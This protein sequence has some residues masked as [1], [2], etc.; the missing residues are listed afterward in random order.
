MTTGLWNL[1]GW[2]FV[3]EHPGARNGILV[4]APHTSNW[5]YVLMLAITWRVGITPKFLGKQQLFNGPMGVLARATGGIPVD[6]SD[7]SRVV[8]EIVKRVDAGEEFYL[9]VAA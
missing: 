8:A 2:R 6:R 1:L 3:G 7:P 9:V 4:G 5:D